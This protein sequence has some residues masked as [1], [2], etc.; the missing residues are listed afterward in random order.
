MS[1]EIVIIIGAVGGLFT[2]LC[3]NIRRSRCEEIK[4]CGASCKRSI[5]S[6][7]ELKNDVLN[8]VYSEPSTPKIMEMANRT[9]KAT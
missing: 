5:M 7:N 6:E 8:R 2:T 1:L 9:H 4:V 3:Y